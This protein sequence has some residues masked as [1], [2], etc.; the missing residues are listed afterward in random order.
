MKFTILFQQQVDLGYM[1]WVKEMNKLSTF[2]AKALSEIEADENNRR[3]E[4][5][6]IEEECGKEIIQN[7]EKQIFEERLQAE[8]KMTE[9]KLEIE[10]AAWAT[11][12]KLPKLKITI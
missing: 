8:L 1:P 11:Q 2:L 5:K 4:I 6:R 3:R 10:K 7:Q 12:A 9:K